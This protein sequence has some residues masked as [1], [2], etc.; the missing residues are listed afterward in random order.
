MEAPAPRSAGRWGRVKVL[1]SRYSVVFQDE[2]WDFL[3]HLA[4]VS[5][6]TC[7]CVWRLLDE[8]AAPSRTATAVLEA[9]LLWMPLARRTYS[10]TAKTFEMETAPPWEGEVDLET[11]PSPS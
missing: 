3:L 9:Q 7:R 8:A 1:H 5:G 6:R 10:G 11:R 4:A 2:G